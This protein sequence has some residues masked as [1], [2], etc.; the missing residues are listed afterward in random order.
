MQLYRDVKHGLSQIKWVCDGVSRRSSPNM[1]LVRCFP[2]LRRSLWHLRKNYAYVNLDLQSTHQKLGTVYLSNNG[3]SVML[4]HVPFS[5]LRTKS[6]PGK[7]TGHRCA[8]HSGTLFSA[9]QR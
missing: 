2:L 6:G 3:H 4:S 7:N 8:G 9:Q 1:D 5:R